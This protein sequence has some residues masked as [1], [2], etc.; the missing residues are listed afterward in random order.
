[1]CKNTRRYSIVFA[2]FQHTHFASEL[3]GLGSATSGQCIHPAATV[4]GS[5][6]YSHVACDI[7]TDF[8]RK[9]FAQITIRSSSR[10]SPFS[11]N[12][13]MSIAE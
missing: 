10:A 7:V 4:L 1:M 13:G 5:T 3:Q 2:E 6:R 11:R 12:S 8:A 9:S